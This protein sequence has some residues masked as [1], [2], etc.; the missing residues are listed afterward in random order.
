MELPRERFARDLQRVLRC[1]TAIEQHARQAA[2][3]P[4]EAAC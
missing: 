1:L 4:I 3:R 2:V